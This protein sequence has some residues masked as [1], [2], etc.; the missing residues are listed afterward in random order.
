LT[1]EE[2]KKIVKEHTAFDEDA[3]LYFDPEKQQ[4]WFDKVNKQ[5]REFRNHSH[6]LDPGRK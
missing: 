5:L 6:D 4:W 3:S 1:Q 2:N